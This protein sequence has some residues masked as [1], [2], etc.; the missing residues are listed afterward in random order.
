[1]AL[2]VPNE[3]EA[4]MLN[5]ILGKLATGDLKLH[6]YTTQTSLPV[7]G[8][9][10]ATYSVNELVATGYSEYTMLNANWT[11]TAGEP[12]EAVHIEVD[13]AITAGG[14]GDVYGYYVTDSGNTKL[15]W[16]EQFSDG[17]YNVPTVGSIFV[18]PKIQLA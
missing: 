9:V 4:E 8:D 5:R 15:Y 18:T 13:F 14:T 7:E 11:V 1:M 2:L 16:A 17:P 10:Y 3:G 6:L 12:T